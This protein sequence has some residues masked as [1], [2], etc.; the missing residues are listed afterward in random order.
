M[1]IW[2]WICFIIVMLW[3]CNNDHLLVCQY[4][5]HYGNYSCV[6]FDA[7]CTLIP[8]VFASFTCTYYIPSVPVW[9]LCYILSAT[10]IINRLNSESELWQLCYSYFNTWLSHWAWCIKYIPTLTQL[11]IKGFQYIIY[12]IN[13]GGKKE[14]SFNLTNSK[15]KQY[16]L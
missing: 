9:M 1:Q 8:A 7:A 3:L 10:M 16:A 5:N 4:D 14:C 15:A 6:N 12:Q 2:K 13:H 11:N